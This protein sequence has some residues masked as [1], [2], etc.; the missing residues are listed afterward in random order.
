M[1][2]SLAKTGSSKIN[3]T[4]LL[5]TSINA[6]ALNLNRMDDKEDLVNLTENE[7]KIINEFVYLLEKSKQLFNGLRFI[8]NFFINMINLEINNQ[9]RSSRIL[10]ASCDYLI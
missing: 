7:R 5:L 9:S 8:F 3:T 6:N 10:E 2:N 1:S 4:N